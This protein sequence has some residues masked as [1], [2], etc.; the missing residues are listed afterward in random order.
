LEGVEKYVGGMRVKKEI[1]W[2]WRMKEEGGLGG[3]WH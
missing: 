3:W 1:K 2:G